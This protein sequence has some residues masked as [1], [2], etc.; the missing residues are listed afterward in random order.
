MP[1]QSYSKQSFVYRAGINYVS[2]K[3]HLFFMRIAH[4]LHSYTYRCYF[5]IVR[6][7]LLYC[8]HIILIFWIQFYYILYA[9]VPGVTSLAHPC[10]YI[11]P[12]LPPLAPSVA[13]I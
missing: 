8:V 1:W 5:I 7:L 2:L 6:E 9:A 13:L 3:Y 10:E 12:P 11:T 4:K